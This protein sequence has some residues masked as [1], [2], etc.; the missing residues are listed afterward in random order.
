M[1]EKE[2]NWL[3]VGLGAIAGKRVA[4][5][6]SS[7]SPGR[8]VALCDIV[9]ERLEAFSNE[10]DV[11]ETYQD[12]RRA[13]KHSSANAVYLATPVHMHSSMAAQVLKSGRHVLVEKPLGL[14]EEDSGTAL[15][16]AQDADLVSG[17]AYYRRCYPCYD[18]A[19]NMLSNGAFGKV[20]LVRMTYF[21]WNDP[22][23]DDPQ[24]YW[25]V[26]RKKSGGG[27]V[28]D[29]GSHMFDVM[30]GLLGLPTH[31]YAR[32][33]TL[34]HSY[35]VEDSAVAVMRLASG[36]DVVC[37]F[38]WNS[39]TWSHEFEII[40]TEAKVKWH[41]YDSGRI[42]KT[43]GRDIQELEMPNAANVHLPIVMDFVDAVTTGREPVVPLREAVKTNVIIDAIYESARSGR[44][45]Q[46]SL[47]QE[48]EV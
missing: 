38:N 27:P 31:V 34:I 9:P 20:V 25:R 8:L 14:S 17:C 22:S 35:E 11:G 6:L 42:T 44:D 45:V 41:P 1:A 36:A 29:M 16:A 24:A 37:S 30:V 40:G 26:V 10:Y 3:L 32:A 43:V 4:S 2:V 39:R 5:A 23:P 12:F 46:I 18:D 13:L 21:S 33:Q 47:S 15:R 48:S 28:A 19:R 7:A